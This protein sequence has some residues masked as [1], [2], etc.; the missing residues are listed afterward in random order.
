M[1][2][3][4][5][6]RLKRLTEIFNRESV[7][8]EMLEVAL[9][10]FREEFRVDRA[11]LLYP[12]EPEARLCSIRCESVGPGLV[13]LGAGKKSVVV[14]QEMAGLVREML[15]SDR[16]VVRHGGAAWASCYEEGMV[17][18][19]RSEL[20]MALKMKNDR[21]WGLWLLRCSGDAGWSREEI[22][23]FQY[24]ALRLRDA[25]ETANLLATVKKDI[26]KRQKVDAELARSEQRLVR[27]RERCRL[28]LEMVHDG[29]LVA[30]ADTGVILEANRRAAELV[31]RSEAELRGMDWID[32]YPPEEREQ[33][34]AWLGALEDPVAAGRSFLVQHSDGHRIP[35]EVSVARLHM[36]GR[37]VVQAIVHD[38]SERVE[39]KAHG[40]LLRAAV[41]Q[42]AESVVVADPQGRV[43]YVNSAFARS[44]G[45]GHEEVRGR[46]TGF[47]DPEA[48]G[49]EY[50]RLIW[51][52][53]SSGRVWR[54]TLPNR[55]KDG[56][57]F[58]EEA[59]I[60][61]VRS[62]EGEI[63]H[64]VAVKRDITREREKAE[65]LRQAQKM[66]AIG[67]LAGGV[68]HDFNNI[69]TAILGFAELS[70]LRA[71]SDPLLSSNLQEII[72]A[73]DRAAGLID[74]ILTFSR[75]TEKHLASLQVAMIV[76][77][78][79]RLLR[80]SLPA[81]I[82][83]IADI[84]TRAMVR[85]DPTQMHQVIM[86]LCTNAWQAMVND[87]GW[88]RV[89]L[90]TVQVDGHK[91]LQVDGLDSG[92]YVRLQVEDN[93]RG[94]EPRH[95]NRI[96]EPYFTTRK[97]DEGTGL[98]LAVVH[99]IVSEHGG[100]ITVESA[101][102]KGS[103]FTVYLPAVEGMAV[104]QEAGEPSIEKGEG[105]ILVVDD[106]QQVVDYEVQVLE[107]AGYVTYGHTSSQQALAAFT[108]LHGSLDL[109]ITDM[110]MPELTGLQFFDR[111]RKIDP[112]MPV[113][114]CTGYSEHVT[115]ESSREMGINGY[116]AKPFT[117]EQL[118]HEVK[119]VLDE[120]RS[121]R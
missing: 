56:T 25:C 24:A 39:I 103:C 116:L 33:C 55:R 44:T 50:H 59:T 108:E 92:R 46:T 19:V 81:N 67:T 41:G 31:G 70:L 83:L 45:Y 109:V 101:P 84:R 34:R 58:E 38:V 95:I 100:T 35:V 5:L 13:P 36:D 120:T 48:T 118:A 66:Q 22:D 28:L 47:L 82:E 107:L 73:A 57:L 102:G 93:G 76:K 2:S 87:E 26:V 18:P 91:G 72:R 52:E 77:E 94:I 80:A 7:S 86:N 63:R 49:R 62:E 1:A 4:I 69:L 105:R 61:P 27:W 110:A 78:V 3:Q 20:A 29:V 98:G 14:S 104:E 88:I 119:R 23:L 89:S 21:A 8:V 32:L 30:D 9:G 99:G 6:E 42:V 106:E 114:L 71:D 79:L 11:C 43:E 113:V 15:R 97:Q 65:R 53:I 16:P 96:F 115:A 111:I 10:R 68:A 17:T 64:F 112:G 51:Q 37:S 74:Q 121:R 12:C 75:Q 85:A 117:A 54:G 90:D 40:R 60:T